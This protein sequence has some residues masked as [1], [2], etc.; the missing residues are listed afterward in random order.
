MTVMRF[1]V[2]CS[3]AFA[4]VQLILTI[5][6]VVFII[7]NDSYLTYRVCVV[8]APQRQPRPPINAPNPPELSPKTTSILENTSNTHPTLIQLYN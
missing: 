8:F 5:G 6:S 1:C 7:E 3:G 2:M 4:L